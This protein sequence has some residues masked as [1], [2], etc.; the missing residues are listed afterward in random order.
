MPIF[1]VFT[2]PRPPYEQCGYNN[3]EHNALRACVCPMAQ[4][5]CNRQ[6]EPATGQCRACSA[7]GTCARFYRSQAARGT[8][9][10][11]ET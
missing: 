5:P 11:V 10:T 2:V 3:T 4:R 9:E 8:Q 1:D 6:L 7:C